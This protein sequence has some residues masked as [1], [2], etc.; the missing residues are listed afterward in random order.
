MFHFVTLEVAIQAPVGA[1]F[2]DHSQRDNYHREVPA[3]PSTAIGPDPDAVFW[4]EGAAA[5]T[6]LRIR[7]DETALLSSPGNGR[8]YRVGIAG[9]DDPET[10]PL[11]GDRRRG[12][13]PGP[14]VHLPPRS[15]RAPRRRS[16]RRLPRLRP[17][18]IMIITP[19]RPRPRQE[20]YPCW[21]NFGTP[22]RSPRSRPWHV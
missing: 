9:L 1:R 22:T 21:L 8:T 10:V 17:T 11:P 7:D 20:R 2:V 16:H 15:Q 14:G 3:D 5:A 12:R 13:E 19:I 18:L 4:V 6:S